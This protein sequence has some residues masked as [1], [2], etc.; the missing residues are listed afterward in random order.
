MKTFGSALLGLGVICLSS[1]A[2]AQGTGGPSYTSAAGRSPVAPGVAAPR[3]GAAPAQPT[4]GMGTGT[5][6]ISP[7]ASEYGTPIPG[8][9]TR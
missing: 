4:Q 8:V 7:S 2:Q 1:L 9:T 6:T 5:R 3:S